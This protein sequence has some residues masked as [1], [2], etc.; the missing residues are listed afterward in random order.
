M[1]FC[2]FSDRFNS[3]FR[4]KLK[5]WCRINSVFSYCSIK[6][7]VAKS[8]FHITLDVTTSDQNQSSD[9]NPGNSGFMLTS[10]KLR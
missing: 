10:R 2:E 6:T 3:D 9:I 8:G 4:L 7:C 5:I 1:N